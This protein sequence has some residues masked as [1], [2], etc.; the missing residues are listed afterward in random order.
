MIDVGTLEISS[1]VLVMIAPYQNCPQKLIGGGD[2]GVEILKFGPDF[3]KIGGSLTPKF[4][5]FGKPLG[6]ATSPEN[7][8]RQSSETKKLKSLEHYVP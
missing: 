1:A 4:D 3:P 5:I 7:F 8:V 6:R 2:M